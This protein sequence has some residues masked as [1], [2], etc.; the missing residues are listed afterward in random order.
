VSAAATRWTVVVCAYTWDRFDQTV[1][2]VEA[3]LAQ[4]ERPEVIV[5]ADHN[6]ALGGALAGRLPGATVVPNT[7]R[8]GLGGARNSGVAAASGELVAFVDDDAEPTATWLAELGVPFADPDVVGVGG[9]VVPA[10]DGAA[11]GWFPAEFLWVVGCSYRGMARGSG[12]RNPLGCNMAFR[13]SELEAVGG[14][15]QTLGRL[16]NLPFGIEETELCVRLLRTRPDARIVVVADA[17]VR[18]HVPADRQAV[19]YFLARCYYEG[20]GKALLRDLET[21]AALSSERS[22]ALRVLPVAM[23]REAARAA[24]LDRPLARLGRIGGIGGGLGAAGIGYL[25]GRVRSLGRRRLE[26][27]GLGQA[28]E[29]APEPSAGLPPPGIAGIRP[30]PDG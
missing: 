23:L 1:A 16:G 14:F 24:T 9:E 18:H 21:G 5:V 2:C 27:G 12:V 6:D 22:Y 8:A 20:V 19:R 10:W 11:P 29:E 30:E 15:G 28:L 7:Q 17:V 25:V 4:P 26:P 3:A 13:R